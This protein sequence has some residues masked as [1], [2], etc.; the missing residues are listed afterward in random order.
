MNGK[1]ALLALNEISFLFVITPFW[2]SADELVSRG[3]TYGTTNCY[4]TDI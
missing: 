3:D 2:F 4:H 1:S